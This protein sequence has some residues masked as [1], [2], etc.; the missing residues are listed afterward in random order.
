MESWL[1]GDGLTRGWQF[2]NRQF[3]KDESR[4]RYIG[5][6]LAGE[7]KSLLVVPIV[8]LPVQTRMC[9]LIHCGETPYGRVVRFPDS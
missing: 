4:E 7:F 3:S 2:E 5:R 6:Q 9:L 8:S 1:L